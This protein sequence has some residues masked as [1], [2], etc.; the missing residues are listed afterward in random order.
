MICVPNVSEGRN[1]IFIEEL[2]EALERDGARVLDVHSDPVHNR[3]VFTAVGDESSLVEGA[4]LLAVAASAIDLTIHGGVHP[5]LGGL[6]VCP[7]VGAA[8]DLR[9]PIRVARSTARSIG[10]G[11]GLPVFL[12]G[13][14]ARRPETRSLPQLRKGGLSELRRRTVD[15]ALVPDEGPPGIDPARG[16]VCVGARGPL[17][18]FNVLLESDEDTARRIAAGARAGGGGPAGIRALGWR[19]D[20][21]IAQVS[22]NLTDPDRTGIDDAFDVVEALARGEGVKVNACEIVG[23]PFERYLPDE[24]REAARLLIKPGRSLE[25]ALRS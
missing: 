11:A 20:N 5:R 15:E 9:Q 18:A 23:L 1:Q 12:Y 17:I 8:D 2:Q 3:S 10:M 6:D 25:S 13:A 22:M 14:A 4:T 16:V 19:L 7:F 24:K 21:R